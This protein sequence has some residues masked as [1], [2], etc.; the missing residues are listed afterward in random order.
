MRTWGSPDGEPDRADVIV[1]LRPVSGPGRGRRAWIPAVGLVLTLGALIGAGV[2]GHVASPDPRSGPAVHAAAATGAEDVAAAPS[3]Q[4]AARAPSLGR[5]DGGA[6]GS[7]SPM[8]V[9][10]PQAGYQVSNAVDD[11]HPPI[12]SS[13]GAL[14]IFGFGPRIGGEAFDG[15]IQV[16]VGTPAV[17]AV[18]AGRRGPTVVSGMTLEALRTRYLEVTPGRVVTR[19]ARDVDGQLSVFLRIDDGAAGMR[20]VA[21]VVH[22]GR[23][24]VLTATGFGR[25]FGA[26]SDAPAEVG[27]EKFVAGFSFATRTAGGPGSD[28]DDVPRLR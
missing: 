18:V 17:G 5:S 10:V 13:R 8:L 4:P 20:A 24:F 9:A 23:T 27:L 2:L 25:L 3:E 22:G 19:S 7:G 12:I 11:A 1:P 26:V 28:M 15:T 21:L 16:S 14:A 6:P